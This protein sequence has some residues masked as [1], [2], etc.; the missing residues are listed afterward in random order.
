MR[1]RKA[2]EAENSFTPSGELESRRAAH[3]AEADNDH[4]ISVRHVATLKG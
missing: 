3:R 4:I 1:W 2:V